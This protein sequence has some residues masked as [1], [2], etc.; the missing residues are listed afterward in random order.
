MVTSS[1]SFLQLSNVRNTYRTNFWQSVVLKAA[2]NY[3]GNTSMEVGVRVIRE[4]PYDGKQVIATTAHLTFV[5]I[6]KDKHPLRY[7]RRQQMKKNVMRML[8]C[9]FKPGKNYSAKSIT[10]CLI[11]S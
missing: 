6:D 7:C 8:N 1:H 10:N 11:A 2:V 3:V 9:V 4:N 5:A